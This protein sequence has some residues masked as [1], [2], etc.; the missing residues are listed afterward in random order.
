MIKIAMIGAAGR[1]GRKI[2]E[3]LEK[4]NNFEIIGAIDS[5]NSKL[6]EQKV[7]FDSHENFVYSYDLEAIIKDIDIAIDFSAANVTINNLPIF[8]KYKKA[9][10]IG[11]T[12]FDELQIKTIENCSKNIPIVLSPN[13]SIGV[14]VFFKVLA[15]T[16]K[17]LKDYDIEILEI[18]HNQKK[19]SPS[20]TAMKIGDIILENTKKGKENLIFGRHGILGERQKDEIGIHSVRMGD[21]VGEH[22][23]YFCGNNERLEITH[24]AH[25]RDNFASGAIRA[26]RWLAEK[27]QNGL[28]D[29]FDV[30]GI[31]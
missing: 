9:L 10:V 27:K 20:G 29:M 16:T 2:L 12:G 26:A 3:L 30:L 11:T 4:D 7:F 18:H 25:S 14:N 23:V 31:K 22:T 8:E 17:L 21:I 28:Y 13:M 24:K 6:I 1:M 19:D 15:D 5:K